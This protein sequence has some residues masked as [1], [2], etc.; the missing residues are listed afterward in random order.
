MSS[1]S[2]NLLLILMTLPYFKSKSGLSSAFLSRRSKLLMALSSSAFIL[3]LGMPLPSTKT[4]LSAIANPL[5][6]SSLPLK[7]RK[8]SLPS[9]SMIPGRNPTSCS[10]MHRPP[11]F[12]PLIWSSFKPLLSHRNGFGLLEPLHPSLCSPCPFPSLKPLKS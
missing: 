9:A 8:T 4:L 10:S 12:L 11:R 5:L 1:T 6:L 2:R 7:S 3:P